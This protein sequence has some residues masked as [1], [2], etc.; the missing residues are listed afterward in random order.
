V[1]EIGDLLDE[2][3][4]RDRIGQVGIEPRVD[5]SAAIDLTCVCAD[6]TRR[7]RGRPRLS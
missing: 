1:A 5:R 6:G 7:R 4:G 3:L 2:T